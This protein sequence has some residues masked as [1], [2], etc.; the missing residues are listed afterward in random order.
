MRG[1]SMTIAMLIGF[2][3]C[4]DGGEPGEEPDGGEVLAW[5]YPRSPSATP[6]LARVALPDLTGEPGLVGT[7]VKI[8][9]CVKDARA[10]EKSVCRPASTAARGADGTFLDIRPPAQATRRRFSPG[11]GP[12]RTQA[13][14]WSRRAPSRQAARSEPPGRHD[15]RRGRSRHSRCAAFRLALPRRSGPEPT[16][17]QSGE[18]ANGA[19]WSR[20]SVRS[21]PPRRRRGRARRRSPGTARR[22]S[23]PW[24]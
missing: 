16:R 8:F 20:D 12:C 4:S 21:R 10:E 24:R 15:R 9:N 7:R 6:D 23:M 11:S 5:V 18:P 14:S 3:A 1:M 22:N 13:R 19:G 17:T 2:S